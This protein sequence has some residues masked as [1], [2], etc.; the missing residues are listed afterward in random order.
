FE[1]PALRNLP[2]GDLSGVHLTYDEVRTNCIPLD[3][4]LYPTVDWP[5]LRIWSVSG[6]VENLY[7]VRLTDYAV[8]TGEYH[9]ATAVVEFQGTPG[10]GD[11]IELAWL[12]QNFNYRSPGSAPLESPVAALA[13]IIAASQEAAGVSATADGTQITLTSLGM[14]G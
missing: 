2:D 12:E 11:Y 7:K 8:A 14:P 13:G 9:P 5:Y 3:S 10:P 6:G 1:Y 4:A